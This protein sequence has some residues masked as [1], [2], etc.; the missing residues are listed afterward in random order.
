LGDQVSSKSVAWLGHL[1][2]VGATAIGVGVTLKRSAPVYA[3][4]IAWA[5]FAVASGL[6]KRIKDTEKEDPDRV[7][8]HGAVLQRNLSLAGA[9]VNI[10]AAVIASVSDSF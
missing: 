5:L 8:V 7:G 9:V 3:G 6:G 2:V 1:S 10:V 4:V